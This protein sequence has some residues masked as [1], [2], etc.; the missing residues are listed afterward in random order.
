VP[1]LAAVKI[2]LYLQLARP[3]EEQIAHG[4]LRPGDR[5]PSVRE[6]SCRQGVS[7]ST[8]L[9]GY[10]WLEN[11]GAIES[12]PKSGFF[13]RVPFAKSVPEPRFQTPAP[14]P[15]SFGAGAIVAEVARAAQNPANIPL[16]TACP[17]PE[18]LPNHKLN[19]ILRSVIRKK[20]LHSSSYEFPPGAEE[21]RRQIARRSLGYGCN[22]SPAEIVTTNGAMEALN[23]SLRAVAAP[24]DVI[25][26]ESPTYFGLLEAIQSLGM[27]AIEI[28][29][30]PREGMSL[31]LLDGAIRKHRI[32]AC[33]IIANSHNPLGYVLSD[34]Y[35]KRIVDLTARK[36]IAL[37]EDN[38]YG[39]LA[40]GVR[41]P[42]TAKAFDRKGTVLLC[43]SFSKVLAPGFR[44]GWVQAGRYQPEVER[45]K[46]IN[47]VATPSLPQLVV[48]EYLAS[49]GYERYLAR[50]RIAFA[51]QV[52][53]ISQAAAKYFPEGTRITRP[54][55][56]YLLWV[57]L[58]KKVDSVRLFRAALPAN[59]TIVP[60]TIFSTTD[61][62]RNCIRISC[63]YRWSDAIDRALVTLGRLAEELA[64]QS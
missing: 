45:L 59:I 49:G 43:S 24:G 48:A 17:D 58:P 36:D 62:F 44:V 46:F 18:L 25:G 26:V 31:E 63:G 32:K 4:V 39:D 16:G 9:E 28:P 61:R 51:E 55:G 2:P 20:P 23:L 8:V 42:K 30:H 5:M 27:R 47:T 6:L 38:I 22:F 29:T 10:M 11:R 40:F 13:V 33:V 57:E 7:I 21:L 50:L 14:R 35:K 12:R 56:G 1:K 34:D 60:G 37:I 41:Q 54:D 64:Q 53:M 15:A 19:R 52:R 3:F